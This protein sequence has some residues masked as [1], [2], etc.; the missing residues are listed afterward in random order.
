MA[1][2]RDQGAAARS[3]L[4]PDLRL[5]LRRQPAPAPL[6]RLRLDPLPRAAARTRGHAAGPRHRRYAPPQAPQDRRPRHRLGAALHR[7]GLRTPFGHRLRTGPR[8]TIGVGAHS[9]RIHPPSMGPLR[10][11]NKSMA[12]AGRLPVPE[13]RQPRALF[14][15]EARLTT[16]TTA[17]TLPSAPYPAPV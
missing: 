7:H 11:R 6:L 14:R 13:K 16:K 17:P 2:E 15:P 12:S 4:R 10:P 5:P 3:L 9:L 1:L 8:A